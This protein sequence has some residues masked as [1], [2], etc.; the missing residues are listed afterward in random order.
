MKKR[1]VSILL[2]LAMVLSMAACGGENAPQ[3]GGSQT[4]N[5]TDAP[6]KTT[7]V[8]GI[9]SDPGSINPYDALSGTGRKLYTPVYETLFAFDETGLAQ[10]KL[11]ESYTFDADGK[12]ITMKLHEGVKFHNGE[13]MTADDVVYSIGLLLS[14]THS[15]N[16]GDVNAD[17]VKAVDKY[18]VYVPYN[19]VAG[20]VLNCMT[21][22]YVLSKNY[23]ENVSKGAA[24]D[25]IG[26][27][28][29]KW[30]TIT[31]GMEYQ[32]ERFDD[33]WGGAADLE[34]ITIRIINDASVAIMELQTG[35]IDMYSLPN[36]AD[37]NKV[38][39]KAAGFENLGIFNA[40]A[41]STF[42]LYFNCGDNSVF[43]DKNL[44]KA[45]CYALNAQEFVD[46]VYEGNGSVAKYLVGKAA[47][48]YK[49]YSASEMISYNEAKA[50]ECL[51]AAGM[52]DGFEVD[53]HINSSQT[54]SA[55]II[56]NQLSKVGIK[57]NV[58]T[59]EKAALTDL[60]KNSDEVKMTMATWNC[61]GEPTTLLNTVFNPA[62][63]MLGKT[64]YMFRTYNEPDAPLY[65]ELLAKANTELDNSKRMK[66][67]QD[68]FDL[69][70]ENSWAFPIVSPDVSWIVNKDLKGFWTGATSYHYEDVYFE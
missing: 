45:V 46:M 15:G 47:P 28:K 70:Y 30:G 41:I 18:T 20:A 56:L 60:Q 52:P 13:E 44:R 29:F 68:L 25:N 11:C 55:E 31:S 43:H 51:A 53:L 66:N 62:L 32:M 16:L 3:N 22:V 42:C 59:L 35:G 17:G 69:I 61:S 10:P 1:I 2:I 40:S 64:S 34:K 54:K 26:T 67:Y 37:V 39:S 8:V 48:C 21:S 27:G 5:A 36:A 4:N 65:A 23:L 57:V 49:E 12:G 24:I 9:D 58:K 63:S 38:K 6:K 19:S 7:L 14:S 33:Y 50:K